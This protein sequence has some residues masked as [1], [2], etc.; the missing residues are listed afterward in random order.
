MRLLPLVFPFVFPFVS[1]PAFADSTLLV[2]AVDPAAMRTADEHRLALGRPAHFAAARRVDVDPWTAGEWTLSGDRAV[3][4]LDVEAPGASS[5]S[6]AFERFAVPASSRLSVSA[7]AGTPTWSRELPNGVDR[8]LW[9]PPLPGDGLRV[10]LAV[11]VEDLE[12]VDLRL[13]RVHQGYA[14]VGPW[15][16]VSGGC[17][18]D[19]ACIDGPWSELAPSVVL[20]VVEGVRTCTGVLL[21]STARDRKPLVATAAHCGLDALNTPSLVVSWDH[22]LREC[23][24]D[25]EPSDRSVLATT[26]AELRMRH[27]RLDL[28]LVELADPPPAGIDVVWAG[29]D[30][31]GDV[32]GPVAVLHHPGSDRL[33]LA[34]SL[35]APTPSAWLES[36][37][38]P[39]PGLSTGYLRVDSWERGATEGGSSGSPLFDARARVL[40]F[41]RGGW[42]ACGN[43]RPDWFVRLGAAWNGPRPDRRLHDWLDPLGTGETSIDA[44]VRP[45]LLGDAESR[46]DESS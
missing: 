4:T 31:T 15:D 16:G 36:Q 18:T 5:L 2:D 23:G 25:A 41:L 20:L 6:L 9:T 21:G 17:Q 3:W 39:S 14:G 35:A 33:K 22:R 30:R 44:D 38:V 46:R 19:V 12:D 10:S 28:A 43:S 40:G 26:G 1:L 32:E 34:T 37:G 29:W 42:A 13:T 11:P 24:D 45:A 7:E 27:A 8:A